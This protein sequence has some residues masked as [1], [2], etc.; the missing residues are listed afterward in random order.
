M[1]KKILYPNLKEAFVLF[2]YLLSKIKHD[3][4]KLFLN[5]N[6]VYLIKKKT[7]SKKNDNLKKI[8][9]LKVGRN[10]NA[11]VVLEKIQTLSGNI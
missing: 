8:Q 6:I 1:G 3:V 11:H 9:I 10:E 5:L 2:Y 7:K 4:I